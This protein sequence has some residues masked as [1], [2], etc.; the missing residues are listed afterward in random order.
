MSSM[1][2]DKEAVRILLTNILKRLGYEVG[3]AKDGAEAIELFQSGRD[4][5]A[6]FPRCAAR[7]DDS[8]RLGGPRGSGPPAGN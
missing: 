5:G 6:R 1:M 3:C 4:S 8:R 2:D 7:F